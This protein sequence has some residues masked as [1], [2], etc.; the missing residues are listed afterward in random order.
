MITVEWC[1]EE[2]CAGTD[3]PRYREQKNRWPRTLGV[4][5]LVPHEVKAV[6][7]YVRRVAMQDIYLNGT[8]DGKG[9]PLHLSPADAAYEVHHLVQDTDGDG[10]VYAAVYTGDVD[11]IEASLREPVIENGMEASPTWKARRQ[12]L[13]DLFV[14]EVMR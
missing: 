11:P 8:A 9:G 2:E 4:K 1:P 7:A 12:E 13:G 3:C 14:R 10:T 5:I 6:R